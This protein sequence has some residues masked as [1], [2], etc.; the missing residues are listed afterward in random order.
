MKVL[1]PRVS[2]EDLVRAPEDGRR[3]ELYDG[4]VF[5]VPSPLPRHQH[6][7]AELFERFRSYTQ[8]HGG[9]A[10]I[11]PID[12]VFTDFDVLQPDIVFFHRSRAHS[13]DPDIPIRIPPDIAVEVL[14]PST[15]ATDRGKK[16]QAFARFGVREYWLIDPKNETVEVYELVGDSYRLAQTASAGDEV[17]SA[18]LSDLE[19][20]VQTLFTW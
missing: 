9:R 6:V 8:R 7:A 4:E 5:L 3:Y 1:R 14:S 16:M 12:I 15:E 2:Y 20:P 10:L 17:R 19:C 11:S 18:R 13:I